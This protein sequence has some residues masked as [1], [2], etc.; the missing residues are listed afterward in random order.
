MPENANRRAHLYGHFA[1]GGLACRE[2][3]GLDHAS[4]AGQPCQ[5]MCVRCGRVTARRRED[6]YAWC[7][8]AQALAETE[9]A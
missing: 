2:R 8:G 1:A 3:V 7:G 9:V 5:A 6:G 4:P